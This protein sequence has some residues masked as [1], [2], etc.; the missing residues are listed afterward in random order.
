MVHRGGRQ[1]VARALPGDLRPHRRRHADRARAHPGRPRVRRGPRRR[2]RRV[3]RGPLRPRAARRQ[4]ADPRRGR[5]RRP[6]GLRRGHRG[7]RRADRRTPAAH[8]D[9]PPGQVARDR[10]ARRRVAR[11]R[12]GRLR[13]RRRRGGLPAR[14]G[15]STRSSTSSA[16]TPTS[17]STPAR[18]SGCRRSGRPSSGAARTGSA[19][20]C[21]SSTT[22]PW[23]TT[24]SVELG[25][26]AAYVR[27]R[28]IPLEMCPASNL[29]TG[30]AAVARRAPHRA[31]HRAA[32]PGDRQHRQPADERHVDDR[33]D[34]QPGR[35]VRLHDGRPAVVHDQRD[36]VGLPALR[37]AALADRRDHQA[38]L[39]RARAPAQ[40]DWLSAGRRCTR[41]CSSR[42]AGT[43]RPGRPR[44]SR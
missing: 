38:G 21:A 4:R 15:T 34:G 41:A 11:P 32:L 44:G 13:H 40:P 10:R 25:R 14:P 1:R 42:P 37:R 35:G 17:R 5:R 24:A 43:T 27:D 31:A 26:L 2:R 7:D 19:T 33:R 30:A 9:A 39:R 12:G 18:R 8:R 6:G 28:R 36:E 22:S 20:G 29:Q 23:A 3:R 16:R